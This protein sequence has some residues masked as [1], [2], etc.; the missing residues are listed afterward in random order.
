MKTDYVAQLAD[1]LGNVAVGVVVLNASDLHILYA[2]NY[3]LTLATDLLYKQ[4]SLV[5]A[6][7][8]NTTAMPTNLE[9]HTEFTE[10]Q[11]K[12]QHVADLL[13]DTIAQQVVSL[14]EHIVHTAQH[15]P[16]A[17]LRYTEIPFEGFLERRGRTYWNIQIEYRE[18]SKTHAKGKRSAASL[19]L[20]IEDVTEKVRSRLQI[21]AI[22]AISSASV[23]P[24]SLHTVLDRILQVLQD[25]F[26]SQRCAI[27]LLERSHD[28]TFETSDETTGINKVKDATSQSQSQTALIAHV[29]AQK[30]LH[31]DSYNWQAPIDER[32]L[33]ATLIKEPYTH[34][35]TNTATVPNLIFPY[36]N[37]AGA[38]HRPGSV[39][40][41]PIFA[42]TGMLHTIDKQSQ[43]ANE[44]QPNNRE[45]AIFGTIEVYHLR[46]RDFPKEEVLLLEQFARQAGLAIHNA[47]LLGNIDRLARSSARNARQKEKIMQAI[48]DGVIIFDPRWRVADFNQAARDLLGWSDRMISLKIEQ[49]FASSKAT[50]FDD[51]YSRPNL[52]ARIEERAL[53]ASENDEK[54]RAANGREYHI[55]TTYTP[56]RD[57]LG[58]IFAFIVIYHDVS[59]AVAARE[60]IEAE[61]VARTAEIKQ[62]NLALQTIQ[63]QQEAMNT[64]MS[65]L[66]ESLPVGVVLVAAEHNRIVMINQQAIQLFREIGY[67][68]GQATTLEEARQQA[69]GMDCEQLLRSVAM[70]NTANILYP[71]KERPLFAALHAGQSNT[72]EMHTIRKDGQTVYLF[73]S[74]APL[75][76]AQ[77]K[78]HSAVLVYQETTR[79]KMLEHAREDFFTTMAH[80]L[81]TPL[82]NIRAHLSALLARDMIWTSEQQYSFLQTAD[83][84]VDRLVGMINH[85]LDASR[86]EAGALRLE[87]EPI[88]L[89][90][91]LEDLEERLQALIT[92]SHRQLLIQQPDQ[93]PAVRG[94]YELLMSVLINLLS[95][96]FRY[97]PEG[98]VVE[99]T[100]TL[101]NGPRQQQH[102][103]KI[104]V[105]DHGPGISKEQQAR[106]FTR[107]STFAALNRPSSERP[108]QPEITR[109]MQASRWS[110][111]T[112]LGLYISRGIIEA[113]GS[114]LQ[115]I[116][117]PGQGATFAF[118]LPLYQEKR[119]AVQGTSSLKEKTTQKRTDTEKTDLQR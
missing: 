12:E 39:L 112:G 53:K 86:V 44:E 7:A 11:W 24:T 13:P 69:V 105:T 101:V 36:L 3:V 111:A 116:S 96:A 115:L 30:G 68:I 67:Q 35:I 65:H 58:N 77:G 31:P 26:G 109:Q 56:I 48:P 72:T 15:A 82:A 27:F 75:R 80:E 59:D 76:D 100:L 98:D 43:F 117:I 113:H 2:N 83:Q 63:Q 54:I 14:L 33:L 6:P 34:T 107:F 8:S 21:A 62:R 50:F 103:V 52:A 99:L 16:Y 60:R 42:P 47:R 97:T 57:E 41:V 66:L 10:E 108:G 79:I 118:I 64:R 49:A 4:R 92:S 55:H 61:V 19:L 91:L 73:V 22:H 81:K 87:I 89:P 32:V 17:P 119:H 28:T 23:G 90:E 104:S 46:A 110:P 40:S 71:Y 95:N 45:N 18:S 1:I 74:A 93:L 29:I 78:I 84:Q 38:P 20:T 70:Y 102:A 37:H 25:M 9:Q 94:D 88:L 114:Q 5:P 85:F 51:F 106:L